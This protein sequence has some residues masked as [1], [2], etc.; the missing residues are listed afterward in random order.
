MPKSNYKIR[1]NVTGDGYK[2]GNVT[3]SEEVM[4][5]FTHPYYSVKRMGDRLMF[6]PWGKKTERGI[7]AL[8]NNSLQFGVKSD[9]ETMKDF[10]GEY[11]LFGANSS[12]GEVWVRLEDRHPF[13]KEVTSRENI[14]YDKVA[15]TEVAEEDVVK[16]F[17]EKEIERVESEQKKIKDEIDRITNECSRK[18][19]PLHAKKRELNER[20]IA[21]CKAYNYL[22]GGE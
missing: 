18:V 7:V 22:K 9:C 15:T 17:F 20:L 16:T 5:Y 1:I 4:Q 6:I 10:C 19:Q 8:G 14:K 12:N 11:Y 21:F 13:K 2:S 3:L